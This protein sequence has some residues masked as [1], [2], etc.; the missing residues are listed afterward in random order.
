MHDGIFFHILIEVGVEIVHTH[1]LAC[2]VII[3]DFIGGGPQS[4]PVLVMQKK[5]SL[6]RVKDQ[7]CEVSPPHPF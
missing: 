4:P 1:F 7:L 6:G 2:I 3:K 5:P